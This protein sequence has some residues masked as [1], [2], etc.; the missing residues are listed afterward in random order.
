M[1][2]VRRNGLQ[3]QVLAI[4]NKQ[5]DRNGKLS[6][7]DQKLKGAFRFSDSWMLGLCFGSL[8]LQGVLERLTGIFDVLA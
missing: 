6:I 3:G 8:S 5:T 7:A 1:A 2:T 4:T